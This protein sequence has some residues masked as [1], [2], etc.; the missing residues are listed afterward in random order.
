MVLE[1]EMMR[2]GFRPARTD[3][4]PRTTF[5]PGHCPFAEVASPDPD[6]VCRLHLGWAEGLAEGLSGLVVERLTPGTP[7]GPAVA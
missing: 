3:S 6:T 1:G 4:G 5:V 7:G 2:R